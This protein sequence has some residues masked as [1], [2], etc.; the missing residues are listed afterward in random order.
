MV[1]QVDS[2]LGDL[3]NFFPPPNND[4]KAHIVFNQ[5]PLSS[6][7]DTLKGLVTL[8]GLRGDTNKQDDTLAS[9]AALKEMAA[10]LEQRAG[11]TAK[12][13]TKP[14]RRIDTASITDLGTT[15]IAQ[16]REGDKS[17]LIPVTIEWKTILATQ[18]Q[19]N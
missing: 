2:L 8:K 1:E 4:P 15:W 5:S 3:E 9:L 13:E 19:E 18:R 14:W 16:G 12:L 6:D 11:V 17:P 7:L 10:E